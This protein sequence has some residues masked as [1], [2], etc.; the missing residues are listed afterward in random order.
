MIF[1]A[2]MT[3]RIPQVVRLTITNL[4]ALGLVVQLAKA[5]S[6]FKLDYSV[7]SYQKCQ[8]NGVHSF[9]AKHGHDRD[10]TEG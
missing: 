1:F 6:E 7:A 8:E 3:S 5:L 9:P 2:G 10:S 4:M